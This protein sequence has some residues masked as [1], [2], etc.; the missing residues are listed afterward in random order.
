MA[1]GVDFDTAFVN[2][3]VEDH[4]KVL[5]DVQGL[6]QQAQNADVKALLTKTIPALQKHLDKAQALQ[7]QLSGTR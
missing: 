7:K 2:H 4:Q 5:T 1:K 3:E 6:E